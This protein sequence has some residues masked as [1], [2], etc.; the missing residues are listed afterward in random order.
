MYLLS[1]RQYLLP[2]ILVY[3]LTSLLPYRIINLCFLRHYYWGVGNGVWPIG[4]HTHSHVFP[5][6]FVWGSFVIF[7]FHIDWHYAMAY[8]NVV[9]YHHHQHHQQQNSTEA[10]KSSEPSKTHQFRF[11]SKSIYYTN[12]EGR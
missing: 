10:V 8:S 5:T 1:Y 11:H 12:G 4:T 9:H 3:C 7:Q 2:N 6:Q